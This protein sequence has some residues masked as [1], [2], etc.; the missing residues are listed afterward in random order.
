MYKI[1]DLPEAHVCTKSE[2][3]R[4]ILNR[5]ERALQEK[6]FHIYFCY[7]LALTHISDLVLA[8]DNPV[9][10]SFMLSYRDARIVLFP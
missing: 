3:A 2:C 10:R 9:P 1:C 8:L 5:A 6:K 7:V 4:I